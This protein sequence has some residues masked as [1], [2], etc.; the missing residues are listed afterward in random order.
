MWRVLVFVNLFTFP[1]CYHLFFRLIYLFTHRQYSPHSSFLIIITG[2]VFIAEIEC[3][4]DTVG[5][6]LLL[7]LFFSPQLLLFSMLLVLLLLL[8]LF[9]LLLLLFPILKFIIPTVAVVIVVIFNR[10]S[11]I[12]KKKPWN[13]NEGRAIANA[14]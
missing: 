12:T 11:L 1:A 7:L 2:H 6:S 5:S 4:F 3:I 8:L 14:T 9:P 10:D 13:G